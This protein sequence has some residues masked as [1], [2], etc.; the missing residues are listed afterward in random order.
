VIAR[1]AITLAVVAGI[2]GWLAGAVPAANPAKPGITW[3]PTSIDLTLTAG[4]N[5]S[6]SASFKSSTALSSVKI[7][8]VPGVTAFVTPS[9]SSLASVSANSPV[10]VNLPVSVPLGTAPGTYGGAIQVSAGGKNQS[11]PLPVTIHVQGI[12]TTLTTA[13]SA[14]SITA[15]A[16]V[17]D[18]ATITGAPTGAGGTISYK[19]YSDSNCGTLVT[20]ATP[21]TNTV[22][23]GSAPASKSIQFASAGSFYWQAAYSGD[24]NTSTLGSTS[25][26]TDEKLT[27]NA[28]TSCPNNGTIGCPWKDGD[29]TSYDQ[30][31]WDGNP[32]SVLTNNFSSVYGGGSVI[33]GGTFA[34][35]FSNAAA[36]LAYLPASGTARPLTSTLQDPTDTASGVFGGDVLALQLDVDFADAGHLTANS[37]LKFGDLTICGLTSETGLNGKTV[38]DFLAIDNALLGGDSS[39]GFT[40]GDITNLD[41]ITAD[42]TGAFNGGTPSA[43]AQQHLENGSCGW[44]SGDL[45]SYDQLGW[46]QTPGSTLLSNDFST[47]YGGG[48]VLIGGN[49][50]LAFSDA[51][52]ILHYIPSTGAAAPLVSSIQDPTITESGTF[53]GN[54]LALQLDVD[55]AD[56]GDLTANSGLKFGDLTICGLTSETGLNGKSV[57]DFLTIDNALLGGGSSG[58]FSGGDITNLDPITADVTGAFD[59]GTPSSFAQ[60]HLVDGSCP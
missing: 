19:V 51:A 11:K 6:T 7:M 22:S 37:G 36:V 58:G 35:P 17:S 13:L 57:R 26:C 12:A 8:A 43:W 47:V 56:A 49:F 59:G 3:T 41:P 48:S 2:V 25:T 44:H 34:L 15:G 29:L 30:G 16:S 55:F 21:T 50:Q 32:S 18:Q 52:A 39:G 38:R 28:P 1:R 31:G 53:G 9:P 10:A 24:P 45:T 33:I 27:V 46:D 23:G 14:S 4:Q 60:A 40:G 42:L 20:D 54:V 5:T